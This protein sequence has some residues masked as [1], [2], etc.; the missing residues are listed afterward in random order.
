M[1]QIITFAANLLMLTMLQIDAAK[2][3][4]AISIFSGKSLFIAA[5]IRLSEHTLMHFSESLP[6]GPK[7]KAASG[8][9]VNSNCLTEDHPGHFT[10]LTATAESA[11]HPSL[12]IN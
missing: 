8:S 1:T 9:G 10:T 6:T 3:I 4:K 7:L 2:P 11:I 12:K 5:P